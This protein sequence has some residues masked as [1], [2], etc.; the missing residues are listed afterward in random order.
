MK[1][2][3]KIRASCVSKRSWSDK[4]SSWTQKTIGIHL[5]LLLRV[6][7]QM[8]N[9]LW[10]LR[11]VAS[12]L[13]CQWFHPQS[14]TTTHSAARQQTL[15]ASALLCSSFLKSSP[16]LSTLTHMHHLFPMTTCSPSIEKNCLMA[17]RWKNGKSTQ[18]LLEMSSQSKEEWPRAHW[19]ELTTFTTSDS[20]VGGQTQSLLRLAR[21]SHG[22]TLLGH[23]AQGKQKPSRNEIWTYEKH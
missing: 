10:D 12:P 21:P 23:A 19:R 2:L 11:E 16:P 3:T 22:L 14:D 9:T 18:R 1:R 15:L 7:G 20:C 8:E 17:T 5:W 13:C 4:I 6:S